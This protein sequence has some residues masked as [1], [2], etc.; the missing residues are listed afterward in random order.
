MRLSVKRQSVKNA[1]H[2]F[3][4]SPRVRKDREALLKLLKAF[5]KPNKIV[6]GP[7]VFD[8]DQADVQQ[9]QDDYQAYIRSLYSSLASNCLCRQEGDSRYIT[10]NLQLRGCCTPGEVADSV[11]FRLFFLDHPHN[12][13]ADESCQWQDTEVSVLRSRS[14]TH[15]LSEGVTYLTIHQGHQIQKPRW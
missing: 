14:D 10:A 7:E 15:L 6:R 4:S 8:L 11:N 12:H 1:I 13:N 9:Q 2:S 3:A 5:E